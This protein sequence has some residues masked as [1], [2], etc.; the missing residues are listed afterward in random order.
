M[1]LL[2]QLTDLSW[3]PPPAH[4]SN[5]ESEWWSEFFSDTTVEDRLEHG[6]LNL[7]P[8]FL[9]IK[10]LD[11]RGDGVVG[12]VRTHWH[13]WGSSSI[14]ASDYAYPM[15]LII[16]SVTHLDQLAKPTFRSRN[17]HTPFVT[18]QWAEQSEGPMD[19]VASRSHYPYL[20]DPKCLLCNDS[21]NNVHVVPATEQSL[22]TFDVLI[23][24]TLF[25]FR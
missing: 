6:S 3:S 12:W 13:R 24:D 2:W 23:C 11:E 7:M 14:C 19:T 18:E 20:N 15:K 8:H 17:A 5:S 4:G 16:L 25:W 22:F 9:G 1:P 21:N 10:H